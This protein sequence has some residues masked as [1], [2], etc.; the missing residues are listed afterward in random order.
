[1]TSLI[2]AVADPKETYWT[3]LYNAAHWEFEATV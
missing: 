3:L 1:M 2:L